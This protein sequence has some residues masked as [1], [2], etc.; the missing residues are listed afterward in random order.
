MSKY[1]ACL[2]I[3][4]GK[5]YDEYPYEDPDLAKK[6]IRLIA[7]NNSRIG[8]HCLIWITN[9]AGREVCCQSRI[10]GKGPWKDCK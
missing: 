9:D 3:N 5:I 2:S 7:E 4:Q 8:D 6:S 1:I 10:C